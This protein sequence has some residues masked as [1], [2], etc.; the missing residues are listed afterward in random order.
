MHRNDEAWFRASN[1]RLAKYFFD[2][3]GVKHFLEMPYCLYI[4]GEQYA[5]VHYWS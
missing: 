4:D 1:V 3:R 5:R 2:W